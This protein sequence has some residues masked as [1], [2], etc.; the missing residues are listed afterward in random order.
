MRDNFRSS[1]IEFRLKSSSMKKSTHRMSQL[2]PQFFASLNS[3]LTALQTEGCDVIRL[4]VGSPDLPPADHII[5]AL[6]DSASHPDSH[7]YVSHNGP[8]TLRQAWGEMYWRLYR[9]SLDVE[10]EIVPLM[11]SKEGIFHLSLALLDPGDVVLVPDPAYP[12]YSIGAQI[13]GAETHFMPLVP[14]N[15][16][17]PDFKAIPESVSNRA[18]LLW[19]NYPCN[20]TASVAPPGFFTEALDYADRYGLLVCHDAAY[21]QVTFDGYQAPS[22][23]QETGAKDVAIEFNTLSKSHNMAGWRVG[24][25]LG[26]PAALRSLSILKTHADSSHFLPIL[27]AAESAMNGSQD[28]VVDRNAIYAQ[29]R[30]LVVEALTRMGMATAKPLASLYVW[31]QVPQGWRSIDFAAAVLDGAQVSLT[32]G[33]VFGGHGEGYIRIALTAPLDRTAEAMQRI[34]SWMRL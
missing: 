32:P 28:W 22:I 19:L 31:S 27:K 8:L 4:D 10:A 17:L 7:G 29:R 11:G 34:E 3:R 9:I 30:D 2:A 20:P 33:T 23:L 6:G 15:D 14:E 16:Y 18:R 24:A 1:I 13:A 25:A 26:N 5:E 21:T 12:T